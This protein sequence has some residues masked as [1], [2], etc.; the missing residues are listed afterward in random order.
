MHR[1]AQTGFTYVYSLLTLVCIQRRI[2]NCTQAVVALPARFMTRLLK[3]H[4]MRT[5]KRLLAALAVTAAL[6]GLVT[7][8][9]AF[10][11]PH[12]CRQES[13]HRFGKDRMMKRLGISAEQRQALD[14]IQ[15]KYRPQIRTLHE[16]IS[17]SRDA[18]RGMPANDPKL[19]ELA[20]QQGKAMADMIVLRKQMRAEVDK[21]LTDQ[22]KAQLRDMRFRRG[23]GPW[24]ERGDD[25]WSRG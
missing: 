14:A 13:M 11:G 9:Y 12:N 2:L 1:V 25:G 22:Q 6:G 8:A 15:D 16:Q 20:A 3:E 7:H 23:D 10:D 18:L 19:G 5:P 21:V 24:H 4:M 17:D